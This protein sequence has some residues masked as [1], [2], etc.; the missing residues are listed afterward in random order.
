MKYLVKDL[1]RLTGL[2][3]ARIRKWQERYGVLSPTVGE[4]G[5][6]YYGNDDLFVLKNLQ[7]ELDNGAALATIMRLGREGLLQTPKADLFAADEWKIINH[8][9]A[10]EYNRMRI[11]LN[12]LRKGKSFRAFARDV[13]RPILVLIGRAWE[14]GL[15]SVADEHAFSHWFKGYV[16]QLIE[17]TIEDGPSKWLVVTHPEDEHELGALLYYGGLLSM[18]APARFCGNL[19]E[20]ELMRELYNG[21][22]RKLTVS[23]AMPRKR[24][25]LKNLKRRLLTRFPGLQVHFGGSGWR[26]LTNRRR[27]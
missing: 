25:E 11:K 9:A 24:G 20:D 1:A 15:L 10:G 12:S 8:V 6:H 2:T 23:L 19:P 7:R 16:R 21:H 22:Y 26:A 5:Y 4:N 14:N 18:K 13:A 3:P 27:I 17:K